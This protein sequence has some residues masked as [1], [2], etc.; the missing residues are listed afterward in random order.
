M[1]WAAPVVQ[2][3][4]DYRCPSQSVTGLDRDSC[5]RRPWR[6][7]LVFPARVLVLSVAGKPLARL[8]PGASYASISWSGAPW[9]EQ[10]RLGAT[11][12]GL[13]NATDLPRLST[14]PTPAGCLPARALRGV[15]PGLSHLAAALDVPSLFGR[16]I[17]NFHWRLRAFPVHPATSP[18]RPCPEETCLPTGRERMPAWFDLKRRA[19]AALPS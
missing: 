17:L 1:R 11:A 9:A 5:Q 14:S 15:D 8:K 3:A 16:P 7:V 19:A 13:E 12:A 18:V 6:A 2:R 10:G 4:L